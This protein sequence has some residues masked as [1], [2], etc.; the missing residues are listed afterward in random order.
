MVVVRVHP[1]DSKMKV[2]QDGGSIPPRST[3]NIVNIC[4]LLPA[5]IERC[6]SARY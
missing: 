4:E 6:M 2:M 1:T 5:A 3:K